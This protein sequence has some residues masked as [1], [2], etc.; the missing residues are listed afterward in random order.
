MGLFGLEVSCLGLFRR[1]T[2]G[3]LPILGI[4]RHA[5]SFSSVAGFLKIIPPKRVYIYIYV[6]NRM[7]GD[8]QCW[9]VLHSWEALR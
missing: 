6:S 8:R 7:N 4:W 2:K 1:E 5:R 9:A 3:K